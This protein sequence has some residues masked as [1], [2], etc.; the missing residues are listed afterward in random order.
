MAEVKRVRA[1]VAAEKSRRAKYR[2]KHR[3]E[4]SGTGE[5]YSLAQGT[6]LGSWEY[7][8][9]GARLPEGKSIHEGVHGQ[10]HL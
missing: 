2:N 8:W 5:A 7:C 4:R 10:P 6:I 3:R 1:L 9:C